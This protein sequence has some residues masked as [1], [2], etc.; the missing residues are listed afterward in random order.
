MFY[1]KKRLFFHLDF[2][3]QIYFLYTVISDKRPRVCFLHCEKLRA[4]TN[5]KKRFI[6]RVLFIRKFYLWL[7]PG[8]PF[9]PVGGGGVHCTRR[10]PSSYAPAVLQICMKETFS[11]ESQNKLVS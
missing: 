2:T 10:N 11:A 4:L 9:R 3:S 7:F 8:G 6:F 1:V 5:Q